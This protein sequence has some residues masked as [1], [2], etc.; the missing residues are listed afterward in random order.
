MA[1]AKKSPRWSKRCPRKQ[2]WYWVR[3]GSE[4]EAIPCQVHRGEVL[5]DGRWIDR[6]SWVY[7][8][9]EFWPTPMREPKGSP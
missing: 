7:D 2:G 6:D 3:V 8:E 1:D 4:S 9:L 5:R